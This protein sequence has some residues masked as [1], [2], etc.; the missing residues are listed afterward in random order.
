MG[1]L[2]VRHPNSGIPDVVKTIEEIAAETLAKKRAKKAKKTIASQQ[3]DEP[4][5]VTQSQTPG[6]TPK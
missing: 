4:G 5:S 6:P 3:L 1:R 2:A